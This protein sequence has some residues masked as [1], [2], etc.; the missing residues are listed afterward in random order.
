MKDLS[1]AERETDFRIH[2]IVFVP[3]MI[4][5]AVINV[6]T[7]PPWWVAWVALGWGVG[8]FAHWLFALRLAPQT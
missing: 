6:L 1:R 2:A 8:L 7:G 4:A 3:C 5:M